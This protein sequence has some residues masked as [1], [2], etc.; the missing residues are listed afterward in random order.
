MTSP[1][2]LPVCCSLRLAWSA[3]R[4]ASS[5]IRRGIR[6]LPAPEETDMALGSAI[7]VPGDDRCGPLEHPARS[8]C[9]QAEHGLDTAAPPGVR[10]ADAGDK[11]DRL[12]RKSPKARARRM[13]RSRW[14]SCQEYCRYP[15]PLRLGTGSTPTC[16]E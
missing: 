4:S 2:P 10:C 14:T 16:S 8:H 7:V 13:N 15:A 1:S 11:M 6:P 9:C 3:L 5:A 12:A